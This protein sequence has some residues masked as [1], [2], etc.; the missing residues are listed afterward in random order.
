MVS[1]VYML[2][3]RK[4]SIFKIGKANNVGDR[5]SSLGWQHFDIDASLAFELPSQVK[6]FD[7]EN[8]LHRTFS[9]FRQSPQSVLEKCGSMSSGKTE[10]FSNECFQEAVD[11]VDKIGNLFGAKPVNIQAKVKADVKSNQQP[12]KPIKESKIEDNLLATELKKIIDDAER[13][14]VFTEGALWFVTDSVQESTELC[15]L[16]NYC[17]YD[18]KGRMK[19]CGNL[20]GGFEWNEDDMVCEMSVNHDALH[21]FPITS[22]LLQELSDSFT[23]EK[24]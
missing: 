19:Q 7:L 20:L 16:S 22:S 4:E 9:K 3:H 23:K 21:L 10:W 12:K 2:K 8:V 24:V 6:S 14:L 18:Q 11:L 15:V 1:F 17:I 5:I 13:V